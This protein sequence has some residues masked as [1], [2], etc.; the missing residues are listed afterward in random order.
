MTEESIFSIG[1]LTLDLAQGRLFSSGGEVAL[2]PKAFRMLGMLA[3]SGGRI[4]PKDELL[5]GIWPDVIVSEDSL[6]QCVHELRQALGPAAALLRTVPRR[7]YVLAE[8]G[9]LVPAGF[10]LMPAEKVDVAPG[11]LALLPFTLPFDASPRERLLF[12]GLAHDVITRLAQVRAFRVTGR[13]STFALRHLGDN[14]MRLR[15]L[16][17]VGHVITGQIMPRTGAGP[18]RLMLD[19]LRT[20]DGSLEWSEVVEI[21]PAILHKA[22]AFVANQLVAMMAAAVT[23]AERHQALALRDQPAPAWEAFHLGL[24]AVFRFVSDLSKARS[25]FERAI[26]LDPGFARAHAFLSFLHYNEVFS[27]RTADEN[28]GRAMALATA[29]QALSADD[30]SPTAH[31]A[32]GRASWLSGDAVNA[33][34][35]LETAISLC[36]SY[37]NAHYMLGF[38]EAHGGSPQQA[39]LHLATSE[40]LSPMDDFVPAIRLTRAIALMRLGDLEAAA[41]WARKAAWDEPVYP[42]MLCLGALILEKAGDRGGANA[43]IAKM[44]TVDPGF[45]IDRHFRVSWAW[46]EPLRQDLQ[47]SRASLGI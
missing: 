25:H 18:W 11:S 37:P 34:R 32:Y 42:P 38:I 40:A 9:P 14:P 27:G 5:S 13:G 44:K 17:K 1:P 31:W 41:D 24:D 4:V 19:L 16:L 20:S 35:H 46:P 22:Q 47:A 10:D 23:M 43:L 28:A 3:Q 36:P 33:R 39:L 29:S 26:A 21:D 30:R 7:G 45:D 8:A 15:A 6:T 2:R 12:D